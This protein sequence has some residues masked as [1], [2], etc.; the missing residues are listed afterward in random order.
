MHKCMSVQYNAPDQ[1][2]NGVAIKDTME[3]HSK[4]EKKEK[5]I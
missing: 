3:G 2:A 4:M 1:V 5:I